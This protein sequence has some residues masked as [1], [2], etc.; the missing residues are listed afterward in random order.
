MMEGRLHVHDRRACA[1]DIDSRVF[2]LLEEVDEI[3]TTA[4]QDLFRFVKIGQ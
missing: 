2:N 1:Y 4:L 3:S